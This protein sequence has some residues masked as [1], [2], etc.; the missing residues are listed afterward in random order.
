MITKLSKVHPF[1]WSVSGPLL[2]PLD[3]LVASS[4]A[5]GAFSVAG[6]TISSSTAGPINWAYRKKE[7]ALQ[8]QYNMKYLKEQRENEE[9]L[10]Q[11]NSPGNQRRLLAEAGML[12]SSAYDGGVSQA[13]STPMSGSTPN[14]S[15]N[16]SSGIDVGFSSVA[17]TI[18]SLPQMKKQLADAGL[19]EE[20][21]LSEVNRRNLMDAQIRLNNSRSFSQELKNNL[22]ELLSLYNDIFVDNT[23]SLSTWNVKSAEAAYNKLHEEVR[24]LKRSNDIG[25]DYDRK[26]ADQTYNLLCFSTA[27]AE[28][29]I[30]L[31]KEQ[32]TLTQGEIKKVAAETLAIMEQVYAM[33]ID[34]FGNKSQYY[35]P[36]LFADSTGSSFALRLKDLALKDDQ[37]LYYKALASYFHEKE[38][39][40]D[41]ENMVS[42]FQL[43][44]SRQLAKIKDDANIVSLINNLIRSLK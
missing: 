41:F 15:G 8:D 16:M 21:A 5:A 31:R 27:L 12:R 30:L 38:G 7:M 6:N 36:G 40:I 17:D 13:P 28:L 33:D 25:D 22:D 2:C 39:N 29:D 32:I 35:V 23:V 19:A 9:M 34:T 44:I 14:A 11:Y 24:S 3:P 43:E 10:R 18:M 1:G 20:R 4:V 42:V 37:S 26:T